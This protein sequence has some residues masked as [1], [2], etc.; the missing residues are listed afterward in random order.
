MLE[1]ESFLR[2]QGYLECKVPSLLSSARESGL[3]WLFVWLQVALPAGA[4]KSYSPK[5]YVS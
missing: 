1:N 5:N 4:I 3:T 2:L